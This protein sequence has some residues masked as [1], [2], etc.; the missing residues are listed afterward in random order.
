MVLVQ[1]K[2]SLPK[3]LLINFNKLN[4]KKLEGKKKKQDLLLLI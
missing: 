4:Q 2:S 1:G 3:R